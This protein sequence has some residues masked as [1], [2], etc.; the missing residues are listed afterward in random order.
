MNLD[1]F[2]G[3]ANIRDDLPNGRIRQIAAENITYWR[4]VWT[5]KG[6]LGLILYRVQPP[7]ETASVCAMAGSCSTFF[8]RT[9]LILHCMRCLKRFTF[10]A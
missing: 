5:A 4:V 9:E 3:R 2:L 7:L 6:H 1:E 8:V 10:T